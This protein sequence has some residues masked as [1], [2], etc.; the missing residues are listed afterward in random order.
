VVPIDLD[1]GQVGV[2]E[3]LGVTDLSDRDHVT[4]CG[5]GLGSGWILD[6]MWPSANVTL[7]LGGA[8]R[9]YLQAVYARLRIST[10]RVCVER[11][12]GESD[13]SP[14]RVRAAHGPLPG[15]AAPLTVVVTDGSAPL[16]LR[17]EPTP[18]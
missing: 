2:P 10:D 5:D 12:A 3:A 7:G 18:K 16:D 9:P 8:D 6:A 11:L 17:C 13:V 1:S 4:G 14:A 15:L